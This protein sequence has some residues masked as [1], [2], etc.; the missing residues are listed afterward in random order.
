M[1]SK[2]NNDQVKFGENVTLGNQSTCVCVRYLDF[3][4][5]L[6]KFVHVA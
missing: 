2:M 5:H 1:K 3:E 6:S 4:V